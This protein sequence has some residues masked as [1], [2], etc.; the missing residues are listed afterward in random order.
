MNIRT[1]YS[2][3]DKVFFIEKEKIKSACIKRIYISINDAGE[4]DVEYRYLKKLKQGSIY[5][6][7]KNPKRTIEELEDPQNELNNSASWREAVSIGME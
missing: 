6:T 4:I 1:E 2:V 3:D 7:I 5:T